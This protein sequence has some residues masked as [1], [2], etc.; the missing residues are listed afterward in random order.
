MSLQINFGK[1]L[2]HKLQFFS[3]LGYVAV[4]VAAW[5][6]IKNLDDLVLI[7]SLSLT[8]CVNLHKFINLSVA[9]FLHL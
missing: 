4:R 9:H 2:G 1:Q 3:V 5:A 7:P 6:E 8:G